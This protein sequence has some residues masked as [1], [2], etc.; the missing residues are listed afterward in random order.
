MQKEVVGELDARDRPEAEPQPQ[1]VRGGLGQ[2]ILLKLADVVHVAEPV[3][4]V[5][6]LVGRAPRGAEATPR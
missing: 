2:K 1:T 3:P 6:T 4:R 5:A